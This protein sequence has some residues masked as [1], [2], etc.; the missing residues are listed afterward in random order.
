MKFLQWKIEFF[1]TISSDLFRVPPLLGGRRV[2][3]NSGPYKKVTCSLSPL[4][5]K[6]WGWDAGRYAKSTLGG[7]KS[8][9]LCTFTPH[10]KAPQKQT[11]MQKS[12]RLKLHAGWTPNTNRRV[13]N[14]TF[15]A[16]FSKVNLHS[17]SLF[18][19]PPIC[20][21]NHFWPRK[22]FPGWKNGINLG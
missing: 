9:N 5:L 19:T 14:S 13:W 8:Q 10:Q 11:K 15:N 6:V 16:L 20:L 17:K 2:G 21:Y 22:S 4:K 3:T 1:S 7:V 12:S 18:V